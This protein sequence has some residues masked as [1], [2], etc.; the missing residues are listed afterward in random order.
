MPIL[1][2]LFGAMLFYTF[3]LY[4]VYMRIH[5]VCVPLSLL[6]LLLHYL[7]SL[8]ISCIFEA[9]NTGIKT[10]IK[11]LM[12][13]HDLQIRSQLS[14]Y[15][16]RKREIKLEDFAVSVQRFDLFLV[17]ALRSNDFIDGHNGIGCFIAQLFSVTHIAGLSFVRS[18]HFVSI[19]VPP[20]FPYREGITETKRNNTVSHINRANCDVS[21]KNRVI[22]IERMRQNTLLLLLLIF[23]ALLFDLRDCV[24]GKGCHRNMNGPFKSYETNVKSTFSLKRDDRCFQ[25]RFRYNTILVIMFYH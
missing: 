10:N 13:P 16:I 11:T 17:V 15:F 2:V 25:I 24:D 23:K 14:R 7:L 5:C 9:S 21:K 18:F 8:I 3:I 22:S 6:L 1:L 12:N 20:K 4:N 19:R